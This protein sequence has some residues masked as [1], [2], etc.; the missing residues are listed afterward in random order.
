MENLMALAGHAGALALSMSLSAALVRLCLHGVFSLLPTA[1]QA[2]RRG[3][4]VGPRVAARPAAIGWR[5]LINAVCG[6]GRRQRDCPELVKLGSIPKDLPW[7]R[8]K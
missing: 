5:R 8:P 7:T 2:T 1:N 4:R 6:P 3:L